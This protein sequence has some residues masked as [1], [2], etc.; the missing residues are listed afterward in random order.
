[1]T[2]PPSV[3]RDDGIETTVV[4]VLVGLAATAAVGH[5]L[6]GN[7]AALLGR[8][9]LLHAGLGD[10]LV[11]LTRLPDHAGDP[12]QAWEPPASTNLP[13]PVVYW[14]ATGVVAVGLLSIAALVVS[15]L[16]NKRH[17]PP[18]KRRR[19]GVDTQARLATTKDLQPLLTVGP[20][21]GRLLLAP[22]GRRYL[23]TE[24]PTF[25]HR[26]GVR[27]AVAVIG[28]SQSGKTTGLI[29][30]VDGWTGPAIVS[31]VKTDLL[32]ATIAARRETGDVKVFDPARTSGA[33]SA[34]WTPLRGA[35][36]LRGALAAAQMLAR[37]GGEEAP[38]DRFWRGQAE[39]LI[40]AML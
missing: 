6:V 37:I 40:A 9:R 27:G 26:R 39:Q 36:D 1:V 20:E 35:R 23:S 32:R 12:R 11:A 3:P 17:E 16:G 25:R 10:A 33:E 13:G 22:W 4:A 14:L 8:Q 31:S 30:G 15:R 5:W 19:L 24:A 29:R 18:D 34:T 2:R 28:P 7:L 21:P 38:A